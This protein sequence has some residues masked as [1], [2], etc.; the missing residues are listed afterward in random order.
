MSIT[1]CVRACVCVCECTAMYVCQSYIDRTKVSLYIMYVCTCVYRATLFVRY[2]GGMFVK[3][4][5]RFFLVV[6][7]RK[8]TAVTKPV[9]RVGGT[10]P[11]GKPPF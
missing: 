10:R 6:S 5:L 8:P 7:P 9:T 3:A 11:G 4:L 1:V 2:K